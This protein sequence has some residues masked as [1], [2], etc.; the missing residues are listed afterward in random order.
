MPMKR[1]S[2]ERLKKE[3]KE[4]KREENKKTIFSLCVRCVPN[5]YYSRQYSHTLTSTVTARWQTRA[6]EHTRIGRPHC[7]IVNYQLCLTL[8]HSNSDSSVLHLL[9]L[10]FVAFAVAKSNGISVSVPSTE[11]ICKSFE[12]SSASYLVFCRFRG[13]TRQPD[14]TLSVV[15]AHRR[16]PDDGTIQFFL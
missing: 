10:L 7:E 3:R 16:I 2:E 5:A 13:Y 4:K 15:M 6:L 12:R 14:M 1:Y 11:I 9:L 8:T